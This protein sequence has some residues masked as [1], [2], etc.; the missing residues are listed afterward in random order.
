MNI[1]SSFDFLW[2]LKHKFEH[3]FSLFNKQKN[4]KSLK[5]MKKHNKMRI[6]TYIHINVECMCIY[7][8]LLCICI[9]MYIYRDMKKKHSIFQRQV[10]RWLFIPFPALK[11]RI[12]LV[13][14][15][16]YE[17]WDITEINWAFSLVWFNWIC[18]KT[19]WYSTNSLNCMD[20][21]CMPGLVPGKEDSKVKEAYALPW[22][23]L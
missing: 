16:V 19:D 20:A 2:L 1:N 9:C 14:F 18:F 3:S 11:Y 21:C 10:N 5:L 8:Y 4:P 12:E 17:W 15:I 22:G 7:F 23:F 13:G 6:N